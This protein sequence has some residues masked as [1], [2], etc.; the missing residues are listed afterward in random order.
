MIGHGRLGQS[1]ARPIGGD[2]VAVS[3]R[4]DAS[5]ASGHDAQLKPAAR[6]NVP[7]PV[8]AGSLHSSA[9]DLLTFLAAAS[10][11]R[12]VLGRDASDAESVRRRPRRGAGEERLR[13]QRTD[14][15]FTGLKP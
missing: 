5:P 7:S 3:A 1:D 13:V 12:S 2:M 10:D 9:S 15:P 6:W 4:M 11:Q 8:G 14:L